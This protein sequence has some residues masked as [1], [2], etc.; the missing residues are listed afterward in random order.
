MDPFFREVRA[1][2]LHAVL[3]PRRWDDDPDLRLPPVGRKH[4]KPFEDGL[5]KP[6]KAPAVFVPVSYTHLTLP[7]IYSV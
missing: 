2:D 6:E 1:G 3:P 5:P 4:D 7:T